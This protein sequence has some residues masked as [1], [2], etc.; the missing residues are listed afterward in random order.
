MDF[1][2][3][4]ERPLLTRLAVA[5]AVGAVGL[6]AGGSAGALLAEEITGS[7]AWAGLPLGFLVAGSAVSALVI[8]RRTGRAGR[9]PALVLGYLAGA[10]GAVLVTVAAIVDDFSLL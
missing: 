2:S 8:S 7:T 9:A 10:A 5:T 4:S 1:V 6:A 3:A